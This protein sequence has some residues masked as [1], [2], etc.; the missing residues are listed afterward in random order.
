MNN[1]QEWV[2]AFILLLC[3]LKIGRS[4][5]FLLKRKNGKSACHGCANCCKIKPSNQT[6]NDWKYRKTYTDK[7]NHCK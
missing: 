2:V 1:W 5:Y 3:C 6:S 7:K 4:I